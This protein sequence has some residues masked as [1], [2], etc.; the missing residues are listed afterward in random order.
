[1][2]RTYNSTV[3]KCCQTV[4]LNQEATL[5]YPSGEMTRRKRNLKF[6][7]NIKHAEL[8]L[9]QFTPKAIWFN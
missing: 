4:N 6:R 1:M 8:V 7:M 5:T 9:E 2:N 3:G